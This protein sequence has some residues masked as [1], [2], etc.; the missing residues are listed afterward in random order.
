M[1]T[2]TAAESRRDAREVLLYF[3]DW[4]HP[5]APAEAAE[6]Q[7][8]VP[9]S[10]E[11]LQRPRNKRVERTAAFCRRRPQPQRLQSQAR[12]KLGSRKVH[13]PHQ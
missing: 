9:S 4:E 12:Q 11:C 8:G 10:T 5:R 6:A 7:G 2:G 1:I 13:H 3:N